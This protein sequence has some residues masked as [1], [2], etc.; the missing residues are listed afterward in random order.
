[1]L[2]NDFIRYWSA[3]KGR[4][5]EGPKDVG[6]AMFIARKEGDVDNMTLLVG[7]DAGLINSVLSVQE[8]ITQ[9]IEEAEGIITKRLLQF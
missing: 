4:L 8:V 1:M 7:Q 6:D 9:M 3:R 2:Q 5:K